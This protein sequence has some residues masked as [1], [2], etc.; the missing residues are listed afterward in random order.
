MMIV[1]PLMCEG[2]LEE[3]GFT[4][5]TN[6]ASVEEAILQIERKPRLVLIDINLKKIGMVLT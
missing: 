5:I 4:V 1:L 2:I 6:I 3:A